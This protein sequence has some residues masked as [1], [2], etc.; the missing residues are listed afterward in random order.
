MSGSGDISRIPPTPP[1]G[2][3]SG[4]RRVDPKGETTE[5]REHRR[6]PWEEEEEEGEKKEGASGSKDDVQDVY[7]GP[8][9]DAVQLTPE[10]LRALKAAEEEKKEKPED[11]PPSHIDVQ[12]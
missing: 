3:E 10:E 12:A 9:P 1:P 6:P 2:P 11:E 4:V 7:E 5:D 8:A